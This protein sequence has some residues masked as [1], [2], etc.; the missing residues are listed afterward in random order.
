MKRIFIV[1]AALSTLVL[2]GGAHFS[3]R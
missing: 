1:L 2:S 3:I